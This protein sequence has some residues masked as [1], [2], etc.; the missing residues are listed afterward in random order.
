VVDVYD[1]VNTPQYLDVRSDVFDVLMMM[2][3]RRM[4]MLAV[5][6]WNYSY[7]SYAYWGG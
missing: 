4:S 2:R 1:M 5:L 6:P 3:R 7:Y